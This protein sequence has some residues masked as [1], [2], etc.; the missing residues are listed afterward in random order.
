MHHIKYYTIIYFLYWYVL[1]ADFDSFGKPGDGLL[2]GRTKFLGMY[3]ECINVTFSTNSATGES[4]VLSTKY[5]AVTIPF[6]VCIYYYA[7]LSITNKSIPMCMISEFP[8]TL[9]LWEHNT[10]TTT[11]FGNSGSNCNLVMLLTY[12]NILIFNKINEGYM[13]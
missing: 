1:Y 4:K 3:D 5:C 8:D 2:Q 6:R 11:C 9:S 10:I 12:P 13:I 7:S